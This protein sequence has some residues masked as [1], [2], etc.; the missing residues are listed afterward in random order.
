MHACMHFQKQ[1]DVCLSFGPKIP[2]RELGEN[3]RGRTRFGALSLL[4]EESDINLVNFSEPRVTLSNDL[5]SPT[6]RIAWLPPPTTF[7]CYTWVVLF[8]AL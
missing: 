4:E 3:K 2:H 6:S 8:I 5:T 7:F 1:E